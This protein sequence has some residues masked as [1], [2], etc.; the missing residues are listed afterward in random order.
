MRW[1]L[2]IGALVLLA[3]IILSFGYVTNF[4]G[5]EN[6]DISEADFLAGLIHGIIAPVMLV[7]SIITRFTMYESNNSGF[8]YNLG[9]LIGLLLIWG[10]SYGSRHIIKNYYQTPKEKKKHLTDEDHQKIAKV[11]EEKVGKKLKEHKDEELNGKSRESV[12]VGLFSKKTKKKAKGKTKT[13]AKK[14]K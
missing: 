4:P 9:F 11:V 2:I 3:G 8:L 14:K 6:F 13:K 5:H 7:V 1:G 12:L 10:R